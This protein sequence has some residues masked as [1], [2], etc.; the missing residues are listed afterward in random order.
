MLAR[1]ALAGLVVLVHGALS[2]L[3]GPARADRVHLY[4]GKVI[5]GRI[6]G[7]TDEHLEVATATGTVKVPRG[8]VYRTE[9][10]GD[11]EAGR[12]GGAEKPDPGAKGPAS[13]REAETTNLAG[14]PAVPTRERPAGGRLVGRDLDGR[15]RGVRTVRLVPRPAGGFRYESM[16]ARVNEHG[17]PEF[18]AAGALHLDAELRAESFA[19]R[20]TGT[21]LNRPTT[22]SLSAAVQ[23]G[24][25]RVVERVG[26]SGA[27]DVREAAA[28]DGAELGD[29][30]LAR[31]LHGSALEPLAE[32]GKLPARPFPELGAMVQ[33]LATVERAG[34]EKAEDGSRRLA[35]KIRREF[36][37]SEIPAN[38]E[39]VVLVVA[40]GRPVAL[41]E[42]EGRDRIRWKAATAAEAAEVE[43][44]L[45]E[46]WRSFRPPE[47]PAVGAAAA[48]RADG[49]K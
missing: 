39:I 7:V 32:A 30:L 33:G 11:A 27:P 42:I 49:K 44:R 8:D 41:A 25:L 48:P 18:V 47:P 29:S 26:E 13:P 6:V 16:E 2:V 34:E 35:V 19:S 36:P 1:A 24:R 46:A 12:E 31:L 40:G 43:E 23:G 9:Y 37:G 4:D 45:P 21:V 38:A 28:P 17:R 10:D 20:L 15:V 22:I 3:A 5:E 14:P